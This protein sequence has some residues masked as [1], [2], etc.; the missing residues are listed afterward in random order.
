MFRK[1][2]ILAILRTTAFT[3]FIAVTFL[4]IIGLSGCANPPKSVSVTAASTTVDPNDSTSLSATVTHDSDSKGVTWSVSGGGALSSQT[5]SSATFTAP[6]ATNAAQSATITAT[7]VADNTK[8]ATATITIPAAVTVTTT[9]LV[10]GSV[11]NQYS[12]G[13]GATGG[14]PP[15]TWTI[16][17]GTLPTCLT[18][19]S[20]G[21]INGTPTASCVGTA[22]NLTFKATDSGTTTPLSATSPAL[23]INIA[24]AP[25]I[26]LPA[27]GLL[28]VAVVGQP[29]SIS[30]AATA[31]GAGAISS[32]ISAGALPG[33]LTINAL[34]GTVTG[35]PTAAGTFNFTVKA[36]DAFGDSATQS[37]S[38][39]VNY[40]PVTIT[41]AT[42]ALPVAFTGAAY[43]QSLIAGGGSG[44]GFVWTVAGLLADGITATANGGTLLIS[45][46]PTSPANISFTA[47]VKDGAGDVVGPI[48]YT[49]AAY[50]PISLPAANPPSLPAN[51]TINTAYSGTITA[52]G[53][54]G[55]GYTW[56]VAGLSDGLT[57]SNVGG[58]LTISGT[59]TT[60]STVTF[61]VSVKDSSGSST[62]PITYTI[63][64]NSVLTL[65][66]TNPATLP[67]NATTG[68]A[69]SGT[70]TATGGSG[71]GYVFTVTGLP[72]DGISSSATGGTLTISGTPTTT[73]TVTVTVSV[74]DSL[75]NSA[76]PIAYTINVYNPIVLP[77]N[78]GTLPSN[79]TVNTAYSGTIV[80]TGGSGSGYVWTVT[81]LSDGLT[82]SST[83]AT[84]SITGSPTSASTVTFQASLKDSVGNTAG[85][86]TYTINVYNAL[87][88]P[89]L[90][91]NTLGNGTVGVAYT[92]TV[93]VGGGSGSGYVWTVTGFPSDGLGYFTNGA[94]LTVTG[95]PTSATT[96]S[97]TA[98][99]K[100]SANNTT[101]LINY[102]IPVYNQLTLPT[103]DDPITL[104]AHTQIG[105]AYSGTIVA[106]GG[107]GSGYVFT[108]TG[109][110]DGFTFSSSG[111][112]LTIS[113]TP[114]T[115]MNVNFNVSV[116]DS[117]NNSAGPQPYNINVVTAL[118]LPTPNPATLGP[119]T[120]GVAYS[121]T[122]LATGGSESGYVL[123]VTG[124]PADGLNYTTNGALLTI[125]GTPTSLTTVPF[126]VSA[127]DSANDT[128]GP[129][130]YTIPVYT[131]LTLPAPNP[132]TLPSNVQ[133]GTAYSGTIV[134]SG[135]SGSGY[136]FTVTGLSNG[137]NYTSN[138]GTLTI[139][140]TAAASGTVS[141]NVSVKDSANNS[142]GPLT[143][144][145]NFYA[146]LSLPAANPN[147]LPSATVNQAYQGS[148]VGG[149]GVPP[150]TW[151]VQGSV[152]PNNG[153]SVALAGGEGLTVSSNNTNVLS[154]GGTP[155]AAALVPIPVKLQDSIGNTDGAFTYS[156]QINAP[157]A[158]QVTGQIQSIN[159]C[160][161]SA[162][163]PT[164]TV[165]INTNPPQQATTDN[166][167]KYQFATVPNGTYT[168]TP[169]L[170]GAHSI[171]LPATQTVIIANNS[172]ANGENF[173]AA[174][175]Y[176]VSGNVS[177]AGA[178][179]GQVYLTL[180]GSDCGISYGT[181]I[182]SSSLGSGG[183]FTI[184]GVAPGSYTLNARIDNLGIGSSNVTNPTGVTG[185]LTVTSADLPGVAITLTDPTLT[186]P[187]SAPK[188]TNIT[189]TN[190]GAV[191]DFKAITNNSIEAVTS[192]L[193]QWSTD[194]T[195]A[196][197][198]NSIT[199]KANGTGSN[200]WFVNNLTAGI[201]VSSFVNGTAYYFRAQGQLA[202]GNGP[203]AVYGGGTPT[204]VTIGAPSGAG[205]NTIT[206]TITIPNGIT[207]TGGPLYVGFFDS[208]TQ[209]VYAER[210]ANPV[211]G[212]N[213][214]SVQVPTSTDLYE[215]FGILDQNN[216]GVIDNGDVSNT[217]N[218][219]NGPTGILI[220]SNLSNQDVTLPSVNSTA[221]VQTQFFSNI[222]PGGTFNSYQLNFNL[223]GTN[224]LPVA[225][226]LI[227]GPNVLSPV[228][229]PSCG[230]C[231]HIQFQSYSSLGNTTPNVGDTYAFSVT[232]SDTSTETINGLVTAWGSG[233]TI[234]GSS[235]LA[236]SLAPTGTSSN[237]T[238]P[239]FMWTDPAN[240]SS[241]T[242]QF[243]IYD[244]NSNTIWSVPSENANLN[245]FPSTITQ[246]VWGN[247]PTDSSNTPTVA[248]LTTGTQYQWQ[249]QVQDVNGNS[250]TTQ[251]YYTP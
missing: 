50:N 246:I 230:T 208:N 118:S 228:D 233:S 115:A 16:A 93:S 117:A 26:V 134:A 28:P 147:T 62:G 193:L 145:V 223:R 24:A 52:S 27:P 101:G 63:T 4:A 218:G 216:D 73:A 143:Y 195:F 184:H 56:T 152:I 200:T 185:N 69:Y 141:F 44:T 213:N 135:G 199:F 144:S 30:L 79:G 32:S 150:Y 220:N 21:A 209:A 236:T 153:S 241:Y 203:F 212:A 40:P 11:G 192:Y 232:Y 77:A 247:D 2:Q 15:Y 250:A 151:T 211:V 12:T 224:K 107:S 125:T 51:A 3:G 172:T 106:T 163:L 204:A 180:Q 33:G 194:S 9:G 237:S 8:S 91:P 83:G 165:T 55:S 201:G 122:L 168:I 104:P 14:I 89:A 148:I 139:S 59:P 67:G 189:P 126:T 105:V 97:F 95:T 154:F 7:S 109:L 70:V 45:G 57:S 133:T 41:P 215:N 127:K 34:L 100:D 108:V 48:T 46:T 161:G 1:S 138:G 167:G 186:A 98:S 74:K 64:V 221:T 71:S 137:L 53:G 158:S 92:G 61:T 183:A 132:N 159:I 82:N 225:V 85:P 96:V 146:P 178:K 227:S 187:T 120:V 114:T 38:I 244:N 10:G 177:Y 164:F 113:G 238:A 19:N 66:A 17:S 179:T 140:G 171:F 29:Y 248:N 112:T 5:T 111:P 155:T 39:Q 219:N 75:G 36:S 243:Q 157:G 234:V 35:T 37:Y 124:L 84:L 88:L 102:T 43:S 68:T 217:E 123:T 94:T 239:T 245:G 121:G 191:V 136:V 176:N 142:A 251:V 81:G 205:F 47:S 31:G 78:P 18:M 242:Y 240:A 54:S 197:G 198:I 116:K 76:G 202:A 231:G 188:L 119:G 170:S 60:A 210:I 160:G 42:G 80:A 169:S 131:A 175:G 235:D 226:Q 162:F 190:L 22:T 181:S 214:Y 110:S 174:F 87:T 149:G 182:P 49:I 72:S 129:I 20:A 65:P 25:A 156:I 173:N 207:L 23:S 103:P 90:N 86:T 128:T 6:A 166:T 229:L 130:A 13:L 58:T 222:N 206:G 99:V 249:I 196:T